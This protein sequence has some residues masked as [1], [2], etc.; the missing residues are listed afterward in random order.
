MG[1]WNYLGLRLFFD[2]TSN[3]GGNFRDSVHLYNN[4]HGMDKN[5]LPIIDE[6][7]YASLINKRGPPSAIV[8]AEEEPVYEKIPDTTK[9]E[10]R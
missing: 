6:A 7:G 8:P 1:F 2:I 3:S 10:S 9:R 5:G 4:V